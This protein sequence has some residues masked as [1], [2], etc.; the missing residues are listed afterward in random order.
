MTE[1]DRIRFGG[2]DTP[3]GF[4]FELSGGNLALDLVNT[5]VSRGRTEPRELLGSYADLV[6]WSRQVGLVDRAGADH[7]LAEARRHPRRA[8]QALRRAVDLRETVHALFSGADPGDDGL[9]RLQRYAEQV[10]RHRQ[11]L[12]DGRRVVWR[13]RQEG[14]SW[15]LW[16]VVDAATTLLT[17]RQRDRVRVC[18]ADT[19]RWVFV[20]NSR[21]GNRRW[22]D[23]SVCGNRAKARRHYARVTGGG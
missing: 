14:L 16:P 15:M 3:E 17:S 10:S 5:V 4:L 11:L 7:L 6:N 1:T 12:R 22:C 2:K 18:A 9:Q 13:W 8:A 23:M 21:R 20:D 19:C